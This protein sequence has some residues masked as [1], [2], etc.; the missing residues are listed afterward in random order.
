MANK[1]KVIIVAVVLLAV[2]V[3]S[4]VY[5]QSAGRAQVNDFESCAEAG[6]PVMESF[7]MQC[8]GPDG[9][10]YI[11]EIPAGNNTN[12]SAGL[13]SYFAESL[14][15]RGVENLGAMPIE[16]FDPDLYISAFPGLEKSDFQNVAAIGGV[17]IYNST[18]DELEFV[19]EF[20]RYQV[21][22]ADGTINE[23]GMPTLL[24]NIASRLGVN[25]VDESSVDNII[26]ILS[27]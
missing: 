19:G 2:A 26:N 17:W 21:T 5:M 3:G 4:I 24:N 16:G 10:L 9:T 11:Q 18:A 13:V 14:R 20:P 15:S 23:E 1:N 22:S 27:E 12:V 8:R 25:V 7:P 6:Y